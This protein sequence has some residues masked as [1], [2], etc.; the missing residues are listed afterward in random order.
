MKPKTSTNKNKFL[1]I[2]AFAKHTGARISTIR[3]YSE[4]GL[5]PYQQEGTRLAYRYPLPESTTCLKKI[6]RL[7]AQGKTIVE[8]V[9]LFRVDRGGR[10]S[11]PLKSK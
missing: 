9:K 1:R 3:F 7:K 11:S 10:V 8:I 4:L 6:L 5:L 2:G